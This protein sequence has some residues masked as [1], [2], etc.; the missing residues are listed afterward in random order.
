[1]IYIKPV[2]EKKDKRKQTFGVTQT[3]DYKITDHITGHIFPKK[4]LVTENF[5]EVASDGWI[6]GKSQGNISDDIISHVLEYS[7]LIAKGC[8][9]AEALNQKLLNF[10]IAYGKSDSKADLLICDFMTLR[11]KLSVIIKGD[12]KFHN[13][14]RLQTGSLRRT[15]RKLF[16]EFIEDRNI[17]THGEILYRI[18]DKAIL[19]R[20]I[21]K[22]EKDFSMCL[23]TKECIYSFYALYDYLNRTLNEM[24]ERLK[25]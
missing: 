19:M 23:I 25:N 2:L 9:I 22:K 15:F 16:A 5:T 21:N 7:D 14:E 11:D 20:Y 10:L 13:I 8:Q 24:R 4:I 18:N 17:Y 6:Y 3:I 1:M 12:S